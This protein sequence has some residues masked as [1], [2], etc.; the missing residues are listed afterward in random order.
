[1]RGNLLLEIVII[2]WWF[3]ELCELLLRF[4][5]VKMCK[6]LIVVSIYF[7]LKLSVVLSR[8]LCSCVQ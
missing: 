3:I 7:L 5:L 1:M 4:E 6:C 8:L 2:V